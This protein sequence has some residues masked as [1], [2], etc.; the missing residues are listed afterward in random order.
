VKVL[1]DLLPALKGKGSSLGG[2]LVWGYIRFVHLR[3]GSPARHPCSSW[4]TRV[5]VLDVDRD[6]RLGMDQ[7]EEIGDETR[8]MDIVR[9]NNAVGVNNYVERV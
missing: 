3:A 8:L 1:T 9:V 7:E 5:K 4:G 2:S 6:G